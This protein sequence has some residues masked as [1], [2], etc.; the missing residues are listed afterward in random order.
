MGPDSVKMETASGDEPVLEEK[1][2]R[3]KYKNRR[4][5]NI[6]HVTLNDMAQPEKLFMTFRTKGGLAKKKKHKLM[7]SNGLL[8]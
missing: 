5:V 6:Q 1:V 3:K 2:K 8:L 7:E 4:K